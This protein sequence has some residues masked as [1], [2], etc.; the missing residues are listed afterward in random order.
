[1]LASLRAIA[2]RNL[3]E[4]REVIRTYYAELDSMEPVARGELA[5]RLKDGTVTLLDVRPADEYRLGHLP[6]AL[7]IPL[8]ALDDRLPDI[9]NDRE[10]VAYCR[11]PFCVLSFKAVAALRT[12]GYRA[13]RLEDGLPEWKEAGMTIE[14]GPAE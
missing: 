1:T 11:G 5:R 12:R 10:I 4:V 9:P 2:E 14:S 13:R 8:A 7:N 6:G 3:A